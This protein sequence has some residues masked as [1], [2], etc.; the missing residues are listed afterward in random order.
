MT[1]VANSTVRTQRERI[2]KKYAA[3]SMVQVLVVFEAN[4][5]VKIRTDLGPKNALTEIT[6]WYNNANGHVIA[7]HI[8]RD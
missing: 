6:L 8:P 1:H 3:K 2:M 4:L 5:S 7:R